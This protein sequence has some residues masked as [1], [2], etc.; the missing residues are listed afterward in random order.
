MS[1]PI[2]T[3][4]KVELKNFLLTMS[5]AKPEYNEAWQLIAINFG[6]LEEQNELNETNLNPLSIGP[7]ANC[8]EGRAPAGCLPAPDPV[9]EPVFYY[10]FDNDDSQP[11]GL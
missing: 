8:R 6:L 10:L 11:S 2:G 5:L 9:D 4:R 7:G 1:V 3:I